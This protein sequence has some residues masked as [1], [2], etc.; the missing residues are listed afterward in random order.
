M[1]LNA[2]LYVF[3]A[4]SEIGELDVAIGVEE[5]VLRFQV[6]VD[7]AQS[8]QVLEGQDDFAQIKAE[9]IQSDDCVLKAYL[10]R[11]SSNYLSNFS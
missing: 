2:L 6:S 11:N 1:C 10:I 3:L 9:N 5:D 8:M 7:D 4:Q